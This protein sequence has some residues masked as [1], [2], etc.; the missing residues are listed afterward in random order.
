M[1]SYAVDDDEEEDEESSSS[2]SVL[3]DDDSESVEGAMQLLSAKGRS[4][5]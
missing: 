1:S 2:S 5:S 4:T 3:L